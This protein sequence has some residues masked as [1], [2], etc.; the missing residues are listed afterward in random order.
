[1]KYCRI[2]A[3]KIHILPT[4]KKK[5]ALEVLTAIMPNYLSTIKRKEPHGFRLGEYQADTTG[6]LKAI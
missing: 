3:Y 2:R 1:M 6:E 5:V 4:S